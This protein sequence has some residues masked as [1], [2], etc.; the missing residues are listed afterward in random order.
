MIFV[1]HKS[2]K[3]E[4]R[5]LFPV[6][7]VSLTHRRVS[8][9]HDLIDTFAVIRLACSCIVTRLQRLIHMCRDARKPTRQEK[10]RQEEK[11]RQ[12]GVFI[13]GSSWFFSR[14][15]YV[16]CQSIINKQTT[17]F[18]IRFTKW[19]NLQKFMKTTEDKVLS[20]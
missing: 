9:T 7:R 13:V 19:L 18:Y 11:E 4:L 8:L 14:R 6:T 1:W 20:Q 17:L 3:S 12:A 16:R 2:S 10:G 5:R 15:H